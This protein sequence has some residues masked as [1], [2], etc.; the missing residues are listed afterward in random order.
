MKL[1]VD[2]EKGKNRVAKLVRRS[3]KLVTPTQKDEN[4]Y[5]S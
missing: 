1:R 4:K 5:A 3:G 2:T